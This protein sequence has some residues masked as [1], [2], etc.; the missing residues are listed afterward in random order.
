M[1]DHALTVD[2]LW[3]DDWE[4]CDDLPQFLNIWPQAFAWTPSYSQT[5]GPR[6]PANRRGE[7]YVNNKGSAPLFEFS[8][9]TLEHKRYGRIYWARHFSAPD[10]LE[11]DEAAF[12][13]LTDAVW[14]WIRKVGKRGPA[15]PD[16]Y[17]LPDAWQKCNANSLGSGTT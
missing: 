7:Y 5:G 3:I 1:Q 16:V 12:S 9:S 14:R 11:Y 13:R 2:A 8:G 4:T 17:F 6:C 15:K 10:G